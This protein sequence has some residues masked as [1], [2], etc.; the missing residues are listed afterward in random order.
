MAISPATRFSFDFGDLFPPPS[1][2]LRVL[3][4]VGEPAPAGALAV[5]ANRRPAWLGRLLPVLRRGDSMR[6]EIVAA[7]APGFADHLAGILAAV[8]AAAGAGAGGSVL[9]WPG[10]LALGWDGLATVPPTPSQVVIACDLSAASVA[11]AAEARAERPDAWLVVNG[12]LP[13]VLHRLGLE[14]DRLIALPLLGPREVAAEPGPG[15][16]AGLS[17]RHRWTSLA[18]ASELLRAHLLR[19]G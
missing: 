3:E 13:A 12:A 16:L 19:E 8:Y 9:L 1:E 17:R 18:L 11:L 5:A 4:P 14:G 2:P 7:P 10:G 6:L 15:A